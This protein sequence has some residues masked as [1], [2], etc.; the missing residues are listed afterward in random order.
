MVSATKPTVTFFFAA[1]KIGAIPLACILHTGQS[2]ENYTAAV[3]LL[4]HSLP[5]GNFGGSGFPKIFMIDDSSA[6]R[7]ALK[8]TCPESYLLPCIFHV[9]QAMWRWLWQSTH[10][11]L[12]DDRKHLITRFRRVLYATSIGDPRECYD[13]LLRDIKIKKI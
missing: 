4:R 10:N 12:K 3:K 7:N 6:E 8:P 13:E 5:S 9:C 11:I 1:S 2:K